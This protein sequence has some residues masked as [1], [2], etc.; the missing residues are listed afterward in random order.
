MTE[1]GVDTGEREMRRT[2]LQD[3]RSLHPLPGQLSTSSGSPPRLPLQSQPAIMP[4]P[5]HPIPH[6]TP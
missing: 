4:T 1:G 5:C 3:I 6:P 2:L